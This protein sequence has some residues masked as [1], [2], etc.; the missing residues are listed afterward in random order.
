MAVVELPFEEVSERIQAWK[1]ALSIAVVN[2]PTSTVVSGDTQA[3]DEFVAQFENEDVFCRK[4]NVD[5]AS[6]SAHVD[7]IVP[8]LLKELESISPLELKIP[9][10]TLNLRLRFRLF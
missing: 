1:G 6:H 8:D 10:N 2:T 4:V 9:W 3:V 7:E 5:Y